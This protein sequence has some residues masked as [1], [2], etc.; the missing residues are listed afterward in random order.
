MVSASF[1]GW[2]GSAWGRRRMRGE[3]LVAENK[4]APDG[5]L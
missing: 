2:P 4:I 1:V 5:L 3:L